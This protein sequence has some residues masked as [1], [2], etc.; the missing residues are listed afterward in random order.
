MGPVRVHRCIDHLLLARICFT[1][2][3]LIYTAFGIAAANCATDGATGHDEMIKLSRR[4]ILATQQPLEISW[5]TK[6]MWVIQVPCPRRHQTFCC[7]FGALIAQG[8]IHIS[9]YL[10]LA[11]WRSVGASNGVGEIPGDQNYLPK[12]R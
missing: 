11:C 2:P 9:D 1:V 12:I 4:P 8:C 5:M 10:L 7:P 6:D 3:S